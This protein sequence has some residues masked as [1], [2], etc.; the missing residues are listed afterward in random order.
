MT[1]QNRSVILFCRQRIPK[2]HVFYHKSP[3][4]HSHYV[5]S[6]AF[7]FDKEE[8]IYQFALAPPYSYSRLQMYLRLLERKASHLQESFNRELL[9]N[10]IVRCKISISLSVYG[11]FFSK[12]EGSI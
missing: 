1:L 2:R 9:A 7:A 12:T 11:F 8:E 6:F 4:H 10:S 5:L 3:A